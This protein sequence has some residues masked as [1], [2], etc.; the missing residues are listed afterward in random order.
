MALS[1]KAVLH[2]VLDPTFVARAA[3]DAVTVASVWT[4]EEREQIVALRSALAAKLEAEVNRIEGQLSLMVSHLEGEKDSEIAVLKTKKRLF[5]FTIGFLVG[6][7]VTVA[8][9]VVR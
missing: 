6:V 8:A 3:T 1:L 4:L 5:P 9:F 7:M 2:G